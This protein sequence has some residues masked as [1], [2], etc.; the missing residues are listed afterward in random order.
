M[1]VVVR[2]AF[3]TRA[4]AFLFPN[5]A[6]GD[7][8][9]RRYRGWR[10]LLWLVASFGFMVL[11]W[12]AGGLLGSWAPRTAFATGVIALAVGWLNRQPGMSLLGAASSAIVSLA[13][14]RIGE[15]FFTPLL[16]WPIAGLV[17]GVMGAFA[18]HRL[19]ARIAFIIAAPLL[20]SLGLI[21]GIAA[22]MA[23]AMELYEP[24]VSAHFML[25]GAVGFAFVLMVCA[26]ICGRWLDAT[27]K[28]GEVS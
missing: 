3:W 8:T 27:R 28:T 6:P 19:R 23:I 11:A 25:G 22:A 13:A 21:A 2:S 14:A 20:G 7:D 1:N 15:S 17:I 9:R 10:L 18:F 24:R 5:R 12:E 16:A 4:G 26:I